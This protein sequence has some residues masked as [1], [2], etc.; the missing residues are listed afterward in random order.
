M[1]KI[2]VYMIIVSVAAPF[3]SSCKK[4]ENDPFIS[5][6]SRKSRV[7]G[8]WEVT[9]AKGSQ[10]ETGPFSSNYSWTFDG[11]VYTETSGSGSSSVSRTM[12]YT[13]DKNG[14]YT[15]EETINGSIYKSKGTWNFTQGVG[16]TKRKSQLLLRE[17]SYTTPSSVSNS[18][19]STPY[20]IGY[21][22]DELRKDKMVLKT[23]ITYTF[24]DGS[25]GTLEEEY[26]L[27]AK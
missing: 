26:V 27:E 4:G 22:I 5:L 9:S 2:F 20:S 7:A 17:E 13:F 10:I 1:K 23:K 18:E 21:E 11:S 16:E 24:S 3:F 6:R 19:G 12:E 15:F 8:E 25:S 14:E